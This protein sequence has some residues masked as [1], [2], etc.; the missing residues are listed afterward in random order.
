MKKFTQ[1]RLLTFFFGVMFQSCYGLVTFACMDL[2]SFSKYFFLR[3][4]FPIHPVKLQAFLMSST[5]IFTYSTCLTDCRLVIVSPILSRCQRKRQCTLLGVLWIIIKE[6]CLKHAF[7]HVIL[8]IT[9]SNA[10]GWRFIFRF[11]FH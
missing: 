7:I 4:Q 3:F 2:K 9:F 10:F 8:W 1:K 5:Y 11:F 6:N